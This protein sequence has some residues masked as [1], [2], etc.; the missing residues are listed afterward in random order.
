M[1]IIASKRPFNA[2]IKCGNFE[3]VMLLL[4]NNSNYAQNY[5]AQRI[6]QLNVIKMDKLKYN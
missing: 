6:N 2:I 3:Q 5:K 4:L 1:Y